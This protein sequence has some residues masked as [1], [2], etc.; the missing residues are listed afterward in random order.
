MRLRASLRVVLFA[1]EGRTDNPMYFWRELTAKARGDSS[2]DDE[3]LGYEYDRR[4]RLHFTDEM[5]HFL[6]QKIPDITIILRD[7][8]Y[9]SL[10]LDL[11]LVTRSL[12]AIGLTPNDLFDMLRQ[13]TPFAITEAVGIP[14]S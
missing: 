4:L 10:N 3:G 14:S 13:Y 11:D 5:E 2:L 8:T 7:I 9:L 1:A 12:G 6:R